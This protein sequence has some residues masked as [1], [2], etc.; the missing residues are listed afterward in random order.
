MI[1]FKSY[2]HPSSSTPGTE[3]A[4]NMAM[5]SL[6]EED[7]GQWGVSQGTRKEQWG[8]NEHDQRTSYTCVKRAHYDMQLICANKNIKSCL[9]HTRIRKNK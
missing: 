2:V 3:H 6:G 5:D 4:I 7:G 8:G 9:T 1:V